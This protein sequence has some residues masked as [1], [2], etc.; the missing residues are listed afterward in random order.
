[1]WDKGL[2]LNLPVLCVLSACGKSKA[3]IIFLVDESSS[4]GANNF[5]KM[6]DFIFRVTTYFPV[7]G[8][9]ATQVSEIL[10]YLYSLLLQGLYFAIF[11]PCLFF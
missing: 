3:D 7:V 9:D 8:P 6:K 11:G 10:F 5:M 1:M 4:I 2:S